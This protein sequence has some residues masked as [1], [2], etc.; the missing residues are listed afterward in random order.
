[1]QRLAFDWTFLLKAVQE[2]ESLHSVHSLFCWWRNAH[3]VPMILVFIPKTLRNI[4]YHEINHNVLSS[5][6]KT[7]A[8]TAK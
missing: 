5:E 3:T 2:K 1:M 6:H 8:T 4:F 7:A